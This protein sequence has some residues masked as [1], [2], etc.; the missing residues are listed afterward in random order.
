M[1]WRGVRALSK[2]GLDAIHAIL[3]KNLVVFYRFPGVKLKA[4][5]KG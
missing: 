3:V 2:A 5:A 4:N 1:C